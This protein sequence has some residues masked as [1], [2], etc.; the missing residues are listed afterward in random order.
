MTPREQYQKGYS[1]NK[2]NNM[3]NQSRMTPQQ[4]Y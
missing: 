1:P 2:M 4:E 3:D